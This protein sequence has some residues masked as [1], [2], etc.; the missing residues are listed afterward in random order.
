[1]VSSAQ[2]TVSYYS[3][4]WHLKCYTCVLDYYHRGD[5][6]AIVVATIGC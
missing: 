5:Q 4:K 6:L 1:M 2:A 3:S